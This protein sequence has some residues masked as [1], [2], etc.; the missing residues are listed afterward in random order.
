MEGLKRKVL[1]LSLLRRMKDEDSWCG[2]THVQKCLYFLQ[3]MMG[4]PTDYPFI[5]YKHGPFSFE[6]RDDLTAMR[7][8]GLV[9]VH[10]RSNIY[11]PSLSPG[12]IAQALLERFP[13]TLQEYDSQISFIA[14]RLSPKNVAE[15]ERLATA[16]YVTD[17]EG[18]QTQRSRAE[19]VHELKPHVSVE[20]ASDA[21]KIVDE[22]RSEVAVGY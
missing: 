14:K 3:E 9:E 4:A 1:V 17:E 22:L 13:K 7:V 19:R 2:E 20:E 5:L 16:L 21:V 6:L 8:D 10:V 15:L 11:G 12:P 18:L